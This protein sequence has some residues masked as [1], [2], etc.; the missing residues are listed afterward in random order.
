MWGGA[1]RS[2]HRA[3]KRRVAGQVTGA[4]KLSRVRL[5]RAPDCVYKTRHMLAVWGP[6]ALAIALP[7]PE[8]ASANM[9]GRHWCAACTPTR[10]WEF[11]CGALDSQGGSGCSCQVGS[12]LAACNMAA[13]T[14]Q[15]GLEGGASLAL[16]SLLQPPVDE[17]NQW[18]SMR[19]PRCARMCPHTHHYFLLL[20]LVLWQTTG[21]AGAT[22]SGHPSPLQDVQGAPRGAA[23]PRA[24]TAPAPAASHAP[25]AQQRSSAPHPCLS[26]TMGVCTRA[27]GRHA[28]HTSGRRRSRPSLREVNEAVED[29]R[30]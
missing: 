2:G 29:G 9:A 27:R 25:S 14:R 22:A 20:L 30:G 11:P 26:T 23:V 12:I 7:A 15:R 6:S 21:G 18:S 17:H 4:N 13:A 24:T 19:P 8:Q 5:T 1:G 28:T 16:Q 10:K 3:C